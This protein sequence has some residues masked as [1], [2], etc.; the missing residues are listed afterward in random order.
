MRWLYRLQ[1]RFGL[2]DPEGAAALTILLAIAGGT[3]AMHVQASST[4]IPADFYA[5]S[6]AA[7]ATATARADSASRSGDAEP[8]ALASEP[9]ADRRPEGALEDALED[10]PADASAA[11]IAEV[12]LEA[13]AAPRRAGPLPPVRT[14]IN[15]ASPADLERL[16]GI[17]PALAGRIVEHRSRSPFQS[18][19]QITEV[20][21]IGPKT[22]EKLRPWIF[23]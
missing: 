7:F 1:A 5:A 10:A 19:D 15:T 23:I 16:P 6:D 17:G 11:Q 21:G 14:N 13:A 22:L 12:A 20:R 18:P 9:Q 8:V 4:P 3:V 2:S